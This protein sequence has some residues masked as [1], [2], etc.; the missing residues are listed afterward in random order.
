[1]SA[2]SESIPRV[3]I[4]IVT[5]NNLSL[6]KL[7]LE[8]ILRNTGHFNY[9]VIVV[10][11]NSSDGTPEFLR[12]F[13]AQHS[14]IH[15]KLNWDNQGF[16]RANNQGIAIS[17]GEHI[18]LLNNDTVV[19]PGWLSRLTKHLN[20][21]QVGM[22]GPVTNFV[23]NEAKIEVPY[24]TW[25]EMERFAEGRA[26]KHGG[27][28]ADIRMLAMFCVAMRRETYEAIGPLDEQFGIG[29][30]EDDDYTE[31]VRAAGYRVVCAAD[32]F[33]HHFGQAAFKKLIDSGDYA[34]LFDENRRRFEAKWRTKWVPHKNGQL[35]FERTQR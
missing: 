7:C 24:K 35:K 11:N 30:F 31:R 28:I 32:V 9:E 20:D 4:I 18:V 25:S 15:V 27:E 12:Q 8:S 16:A 21:P 2:L 26:W 1:V 14:H 33:V 34:K 19:P 3:S 5:F 17:T 10:D 22:V 6:N 13:A 29:M 23:G